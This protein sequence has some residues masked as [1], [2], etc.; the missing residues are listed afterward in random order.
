MTFHICIFC[1]SCYSD[2]FYKTVDAAYCYRRHIG[3]NLV[4][5]Y[6]SL[7]FISMSFIDSKNTF[8]HQIFV[9]NDTTICKYNHIM[10]INHRVFTG[11]LET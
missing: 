9:Y 10:Q 4:F 2:G 11:T 6:I 1:T 7:L 5:S 3:C 8:Q